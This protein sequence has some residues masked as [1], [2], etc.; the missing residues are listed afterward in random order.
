MAKLIYTLKKEQYLP[1]SLDEAWAFFSTP[2]NLEVMT[3]KELG[4]D[5]LSKENLDE[6]YPG[7]I[8]EYTVKPL[9]NIPVYWMTEITKVKEKQFFIDEQRFGPYAFWHHQHLFRATE[10]GVLMT[11]LL[12]YKVPAGLLGKI[13]F[14]WFI[15]KKVNE[16]FDHRFTFLEQHFGKS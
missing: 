15:Q 8:I 11:D 4:F 10:N 7:M 13:F 3:P 2:K 16:I 9:L 1:I 6:M 14:G 5:I 12:H